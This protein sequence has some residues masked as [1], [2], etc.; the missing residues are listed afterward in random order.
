[1]SDGEAED[2]LDFNPKTE[3]TSKK[4]GRGSKG[5]KTACKRQKVVDKRAKCGQCDQYVDDNPNLEM[6][7]GAPNEACDDET[8]ALF[9]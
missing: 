3:G 6:F 1:M 7:E 4:R 2:D 8:G 9:R 5:Q